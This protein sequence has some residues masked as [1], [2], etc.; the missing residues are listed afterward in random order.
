MIQI[1]LLPDIKIV[2]LR[3][4]R[5]RLIVFLVALLVITGCTTALLLMGLDALVRQPNN[6]Q[7]Y[8]EK[9]N[10]YVDRFNGENGGEVRKYLA[11]QSKFEAL[12]QLAERK[13]DPNRLW[14]NGIF[15]TSPELE[16]NSFL[17]S[18]YLNEI[19]SYSF[20]F[21]NGEFSIAGAVDKGGDDVN[22]R[23]HFLYAYYEIGQTD[24]DDNVTWGCPRAPTG[25]LDD[26]PEWTYC[27]MFSEIKANSEFHPELDTQRKVTIRG[28]FTTEA[29]GGT[30][31]FD[32]DVLMRVRVPIGCSNISCVLEPGLEDDVPQDFIDEGS[33]IN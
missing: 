12:G 33:A 22:F 13:I 24:E 7:N 29:G 26:A 25:E 19:E 15:G 18:Q 8:Q 3:V 16:I 28:R 10:A 14:S 9:I 32:K 6:I 21:D 4:R 31:L 1:N 20:D 2:Y 30:N 11:I 27:R 23:D 5:L 17:P